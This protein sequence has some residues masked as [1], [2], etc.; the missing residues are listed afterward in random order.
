MERYAYNE[1]STFFCQIFLKL[2][3]IGMD[4]TR[5]LYITLDTIYY[6][7]TL[8]WDFL[9]KQ[10]TFFHYLSKIHEFYGQVYLMLFDVRFKSTKILL[11]MVHFKIKV[12]ESE[13]ISIM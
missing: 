7:K 4:S 10:I 8:F 11:I 12:K 6:L 5:Y 2:A 9:N 3:N 13:S 1:G